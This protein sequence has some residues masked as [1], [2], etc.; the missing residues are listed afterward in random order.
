MKSLY[1]KLIKI[2]NGIID[3]AISGCLFKVQSIKCAANGA[4]DSAISHKKDGQ[5]IFDCVPCESFTDRKQFCSNVPC[6]IYCVFSQFHSMHFAVCYCVQRFHSFPVKF[7]SDFVCV[8]HQQRPKIT[9]K[10]PL[11]ASL[12][13]NR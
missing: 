13:C 11:F 5:C 6:S 4:T 7:A 3:K 2:C 12:G 9:L 8:K 10:W 1:L